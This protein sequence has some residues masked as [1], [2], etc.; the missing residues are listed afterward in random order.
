MNDTPERIESAIAALEAQRSTLGDAVVAMAVAPLMDKLA[1]LRSSV[2]GVQ[3]LKTATVLFMDVAGSTRLSEHLDP[4]DVQAVMDTALQSFSAVVT[5]HQGQVLQYAGDSLLAAFGAAQAM[6]DDPEQAVR[7]GLAI[8]RNA[9]LL[10]ERFREERRLPN[11]GV[12]VG[13]H[14]GT[15]LLGGGVNAE[16]SIRGVAVNI[17]ARM[18][19]SAP[20]GSL[21][22]SQATY[23]HVRGMFDVEPQ[24]PIEIKG[25][26]GAVRSYLVLRARARTYETANRGLEG[27]EVPTLGREAELARIEATLEAARAA[28]AAFV[29]TVVGEPGI[30]KSRLSLEFARRLGRLV[31]GAEIFQGR[32]QPYGSEV[33][34]GLLRYLLAWRMGIQESDSQEIAQE[35]LSLVWV[36]FLVIVPPK[37]PP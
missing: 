14:T 30:G 21:R 16:G 22:I 7:A 17:A 19:Q 36:P 33:P 37:E 28:K 8:L 27:I 26:T 20:V 24:A 15:V 6:E 10:A 12:R 9:R 31:D 3:Q 35:K 13:I 25:I 29:V 18:E 4:E 11:F 23:R 5:E 34:Y 1:V 2:L 32:P